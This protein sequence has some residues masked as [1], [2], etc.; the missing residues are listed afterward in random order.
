M[1][2]AGDMQR[3][4]L[5]QVRGIA[6]DIKC[7]PQLQAKLDALDQGSHAIGDELRARDH[8]QQQA[9]E[10]LRQE[11]A[12]LRLDQHK[13]MAALAGISSTLSEQK[14]N[15]Y[16]QERRLQKAEEQVRATFDSQLETSRRL[17]GITAQADTLTAKVDALIDPATLQKLVEESTEN[18]PWLHGLKWFL[19]ILFGLLATAAAVGLLLLLASAISNTLGG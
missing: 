14:S 5:D 19:R 8:T 13:M 10:L 4:L 7:I 3:L 18:R 12:E 1:E 17:R 2:S 15:L 9:V 6:A 11:M 16:D